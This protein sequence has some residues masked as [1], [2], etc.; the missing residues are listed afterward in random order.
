VSTDHVLRFGVSLD[1]AGR[2]PAAWREPDARPERLFTADHTVELA[3]LAERAGFDFVTLDDSFRLQEGG[4]GA[5]RGQLDAMLTMSRVAP[6]TSRIGLVPTVTTTHTEPFHISKNVATLDFVSLGR[7]GW[8]V[9]VSTTEAEALHFGRRPV[10]PPDELYAEA[11]EAV[12]AVT[13]LWDSWEDDAVIRDVATGRYI[14]RDRLHV[15]NFEGRFFSVRGPSITPRSPQG[16]SLVFVAAVDDHALAVGIQRAD[17]IIVDVATVG[18]AARRRDRIRDGLDAAGRDSAGVS[19]LATLD[20]L[21]GATPAQANDAARRLDAAAAPTHGPLSYRGGPQGFVDLVDE[22]AS[23]GVVDGFVLRPEA[24]PSTLRRLADDAAPLLQA[25]GLLRTDDPGPTLRHRFG[26]QR[27]DN[28]YA[29][30]IVSG[31]R[32]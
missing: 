30:A 20:V 31:G 10:L 17:V 23:A 1:G 14:D 7:A 25:R 32:P 18:E 27:P 16:Q 13:Q 24:L 15:T 29:A 9:D 26:L 5:V 8:L 22:W 4:E 12:D 2:H 6:A 21:L 28:R 11:S 19:V 3:L